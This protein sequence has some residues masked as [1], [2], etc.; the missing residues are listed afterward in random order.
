MTNT[1][2]HDEWQRAL[3]AATAPF[4]PEDLRGKSPADIEMSLML[5]RGDIG[6]EWVD[7]IRQ[8]MELAFVS[9]W[10][11]Y[12]EAQRQAD[13]AWDDAHRPIDTTGGRA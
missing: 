2:D 1:S 10:A 12:L 9:R 6:E 5:E 7:D 8:G 4:V 13:T 11:G 3:A